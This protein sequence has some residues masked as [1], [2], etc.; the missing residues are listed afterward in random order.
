PG[1]HDADHAAHLHAARHT[2]WY[3]SDLVWRSVLDLHAAGPPPSAAWA[4]ADD[5]AGG[6]TSRGND[7][8]HLQ[9]RRAVSDLRDR[10]AR[11][12]AA[13]SCD[14]HVAAEPAR[15]VT[16]HWRRSMP[17]SG[18]WPHFYA[19]AAHPQALATMIGADD[20]RQGTAGQPRAGRNDEPDRPGGAGIGLTRIANLWDLS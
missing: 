13:L 5:H 7:R 11:A 12:L 17:R 15:G 3:R 6:R 4:I 20:G 19:S 9:S 1:Q 14:C 10:L 2:A 8:A 16:H 18:E